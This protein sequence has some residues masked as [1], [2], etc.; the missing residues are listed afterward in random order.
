MNVA[1]AINTAELEPMVEIDARIRRTF[2]ILGK[3]TRGLIEGN[4]P[5]AIVSGAAGC[6]K[7]HTLMSALEDGVRNDG[8]NYR[9]IKGVASPISLYRE[10]FECREPGNVLVIDD[11]DGLFAEIDAVSILKHALDTTRTRTVHWNK[12]SRVLD[13]YGIPRE[14]D[15]EGGVVFATN[16]DWEAE[17]ERGTKMAAH[18]KALMT[19]CLYVDLRIHSKREILVRIAQVVFSKEFLQE[20]GINKT[21][22]KELMA[23]LTTNLDKIRLLSIRSMVQL[24]EMLKTDDD[25][26]KDMAEV[27][28]FGRKI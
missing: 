2:R 9:C 13:E 17:I 6:G 3:V 27:V 21:Q 1:T 8:I 16:I 24:A 23:W 28:M 4:I 15:F 11:S 12:E 26:W 14:F 22:A 20:Q 5:A 7:T 19:R 10:L 18:Y 25:D